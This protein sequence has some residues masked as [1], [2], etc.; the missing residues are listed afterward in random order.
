[1]REILFRGKRLD[2]DK[3]VEGNFIFSSDS[4]KE[5]KTIIIPTTNSDM[6]VDRTD[7]DLG[8]ENW[9]KVNPETIGQYTGL[10]D[11]NGNKIFEGDIMETSISGLKYHVGVVEFSDASFGLKCTNWDAFFL[12]FVAGNYKI[13]GNI[14][15]NPE[16]LTV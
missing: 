15:D 6:F 14:Y 2:N 11:V 4:D 9:H 3:W 5:Y 1:M 7:K 10:K 13:I 16:L 12:C 8:F